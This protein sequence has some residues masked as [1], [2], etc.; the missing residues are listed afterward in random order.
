MIV[1]Y[2]G[3]QTYR[4]NK[5]V[6]IFFYWPI[7]LKNQ[8]NWRNILYS[9]VQLYLGATNWIKNLTA[10]DSTDSQNLKIL[11]FKVLHSNNRLI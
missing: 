1:N 5:I 9:G 6:F 3:V 2:T 8:E 11:G 7:C 4:M 10:F